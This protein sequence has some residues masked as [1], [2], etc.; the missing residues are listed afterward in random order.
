VRWREEN[1]MADDLAGKEDDDYN[2]NATLIKTK[3]TI[4]DFL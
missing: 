4:S 3:Q 1:V 2:Y